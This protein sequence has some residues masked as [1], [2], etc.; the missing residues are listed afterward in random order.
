MIFSTITFKSNPAIELSFTT[1]CNAYF[2]VVR[3][4]LTM[5]GI[6][7]TER[8]NYIKQTSSGYHLYHKK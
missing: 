6:L 2:Q 3:I 1:K 5:E 7:G 8:S 4:C